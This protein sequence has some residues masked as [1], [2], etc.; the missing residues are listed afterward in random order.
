MAEMEPAKPSDSDKQRPD[1]TTK[2]PQGAKD[3][4]EKFSSLSTF[5]STVLV[6]L[7]GGFFTYTFN[8]R[9]AEHQRSIQE[10]QTVAQLMP[11]LTS[12]D[13]NTR[14]TAF[15][16][17]KV[18]Q[19]TKLMADLA[20]SD[21][22][23]GAHEALRD[24]AFHADKVADRNV[25][26]KALSEIEFVPAC[27]L[28]FDS[29]KQHHPIDN[30]CTAHGLVMADAPQSAQNDAKNNF[31]S[32]G[33]P[34]NIDFDVLRQ[35]QADAAKSGITFGSNDQLPRDRSVLRKLPTKAGSLGE[36]TVARI[37][38]FVIQAH[39]SNVGTGESVNC[40]QPDKESNDIHIVLGENSNHD[41]ECSSVTAEM[42]PHFRPDSWNPSVLTDHNEHLYRFTGQIFFDASHSPCQGGKGSPKRSAIWE[43]HPVY[44]V[45]ICVDTSNHC[46][47]ES[48]QNWV[49]LSDF[50][51]TPP[52]ETRLWFPENLLKDTLGRPAR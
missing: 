12:S 32:S 50:V 49:A 33:T 22:S 44:G 40:K 5:L 24:V 46:T 16:A 15:I 51:G 39:Y 6:A 48:D 34:V 47:L 2:S 20:T 36:G 42:S 41:D 26:L 43:I 11:F 37:A 1:P 18:L 28:P 38:A 17:V 31:C 7:V 52:S 14:R 21:P 19:D 30:S 23:Q 35:L 25:A 13:Q 45:D 10:T 9:E 4:W 8:H 3:F 27:T 29:I